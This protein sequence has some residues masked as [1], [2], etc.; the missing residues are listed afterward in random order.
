MSHSHSSQL[1][2]RRM[3]VEVL[4]RWGEVQIHSHTQVG[5]WLLVI[6]SIRMGLGSRS[7]RR[8]PAVANEEVQPS[9]SIVMPLQYLG[10]G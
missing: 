7:N 1:R 5:S 3:R 10:R 9:L 8:L 4:N 6:H 2:S